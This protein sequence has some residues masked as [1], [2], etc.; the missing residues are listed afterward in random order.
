ME[1]IINNQ[2]YDVDEANNF[3]KKLFGLM[4]KKEIKKGLFFSNTRTIHT[5]FMKCNIDIIMIDKNMKIVLI[6]KNYPRNHILIKL[7]AKHT[8]ELP[9]NSIKDININDIVLKK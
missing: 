7:K 9:A 5:F 8:I 1:I 6:K 3:K 4:G 2:K